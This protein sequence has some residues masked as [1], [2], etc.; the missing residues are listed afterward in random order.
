MEKSF[1]ELNL[2]TQY[3]IEGGRLMSN[4]ERCY[5][6]DVLP[7]NPGSG[8]KLASAANIFNR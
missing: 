3:E 4:F 1:E 6:G 5:L 7:N 8:E 2:K